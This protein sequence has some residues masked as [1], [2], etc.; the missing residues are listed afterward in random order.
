MPN[1]IACPSCH[2]EVSAFA[3]ACPGCG[4]PQPGAG[5]VQPAPQQ[6]IARSILTVHDHLTI[7]L[8]SLPLALA[9]QIVIWMVAAG[10]GHGTPDFVTFYLMCYGATA[11]LFYLLRW[12]AMNQ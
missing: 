2:R 8:I 4:H 11:G 3:P 5:I 1:L 6:Q 10:T 12:A 7:L 9:L